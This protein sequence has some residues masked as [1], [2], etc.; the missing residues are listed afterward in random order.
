MDIGNNIKKLLGRAG[1]SQ[2]ELADAIGKDRVTINHYIS[3]KVIPPTNIIPKIAKVL[4]VNVSSL[5]SE[6]G[7]D[8]L[9]EEMQKIFAEKYEEYKVSD[10]P[11]KEVSKQL[12]ELLEGQEEIEE[13]LKTP[14]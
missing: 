4:K 9:N 12:R 13:L 1:M 6:E 14:K 5:F 10:A 8:P 2:R 11:M 3:G 7:Y